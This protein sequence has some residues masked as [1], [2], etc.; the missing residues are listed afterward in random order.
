[1]SC[2]CI[3]ECLI[4]VFGAKTDEHAKKMLDWWENCLEDRC[5]QN[6]ME[7]YFT[8]QKMDFFA[9]LFPN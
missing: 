8:D 1:M 6:M 9:F 7:N 5:F 4:W 2:N 3:L